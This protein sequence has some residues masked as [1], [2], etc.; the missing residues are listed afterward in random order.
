MGGDVSRRSPRLTAITR[1][2]QIGSGWKYL[3]IAIYVGMVAQK[4]RTVREFNHTVGDN[5]N[6][7]SPS[8]YALR[9]AVDTVDR[10][11]MTPGLST[12][13]GSS[14]EQIIGCLR[15]PPDTH[16]AAAEVVHLVAVV[17]DQ[18]LAIGQLDHCWVPLV[19]TLAR[20]D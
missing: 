5:L 13:V 14:N 17:G 3:I 7:T 16:S 11:G 10:P 19:K 4:N 1:P 15:R 6:G 18:Q 8:I 20:Y 12:V 9:F 2:R